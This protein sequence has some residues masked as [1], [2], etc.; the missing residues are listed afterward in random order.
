MAPSTAS[1][2]RAND[3]LSTNGAV[4]S[5][6]SWQTRR[7]GPA[8]AEHEGRGRRGRGV[9]ARGHIIGMTLNS[10]LRIGLFGASIAIACA[11]GAFAQQS[12]TQ[13]APEPTVEASV[14]DILMQMPEGPQQAQPARGGD[15]QRA[16]RAPQ[17][18]G[19]SPTGV[20]AI[21]GERRSVTVGGQGAFEPILNESIPEV[22]LPDEGELITLNAADS[23]VSVIEVLDAVATATGWNVVASQGVEKET[24]R[25]WVR[26]VMPRQVMEILKFNHIH[27]DFDPNTRFLYVMLDGEFLERKFGDL[28]RYEFK[29]SHA[30]VMDIEQVL[31]GL[32]SATGRLISDPRTGNIIVWDTQANLDAMRETVKQLDVPLE[33][34]V[35]MLKHIQAD[36]LLDTIESLLSERGLAQADPRANSIVVTDLP[37]RQDQIGEMIEALDKPLITKT[38]TLRYIEPKAVAERLENIVSEEVGV[39]TMDEDTHQVS[40]TATQ[41][42]VDEVDKMVQDWDVKGQQVQ[43]ETFLVSASSNVIRNLSLD[44]AYFDEISGVPFSIQ[45]GNSKPD[46]TGAPEAGQRANVGRYPYRA[47]L[48]DDFTNSTI[49]EVSNPGGNEAGKLTGNTILDPDFKGNRVAVV[50]D[51]LDSTGELQILARPRV[52]VQDG[53]EATFENTTDKPFQS[54]GFT[55]YGG[56]VIDNGGVNDPI[57]DVSSRVIPG[58][59]QFIKVGTIL[60]VKPR[61]ND[62]SNILMTIETE[63]STAEDKTIIAGGLAST[64]P[65]KTQNK[66]ETQVL[67]NDG[68]T[69]VIGGLR[70]VTVKDDVERVP[71]LGD[72]PFVGRLFK[73]TKKDHLDRELAV[74]ITP[75][76]VD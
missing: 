26:D 30:D 53:E 9:Y 27:Y 47:F 55:G 41:A 35:F 68:Q 4:D 46:Y 42:R 65:Q 71:L 38:W 33:P 16:P 54:V 18:K 40:L 51:Y 44:W 76:I 48:R 11:P 59:V 19:K 62:E 3:G 14:K 22:D 60:K 64:V 13:P 74:F 5:L 49:Q 75:T 28:K 73:T 20:T 25:F 66:A 67:V 17:E 29:V 36:D 23:A 70:S 50:L 56:T 39:I 58:Q 37:A 7:A 61:V 2:C 10:I 52:T 6:Y 21:Q 1:G 12:T 15:A 63:E 34:R 31:N 72:L 57:N 8:P 69:I 24:I 43:I 32:M 45:S